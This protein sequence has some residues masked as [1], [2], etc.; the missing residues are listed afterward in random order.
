MALGTLGDVDE[1]PALLSLAFDSNCFVRCAAVDEA[2][3]IW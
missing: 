2:I 3:T 1:K